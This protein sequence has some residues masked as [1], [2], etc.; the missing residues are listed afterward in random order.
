MKRIICLL[1]LGLLYP[2][3]IEAGVSFDLGGEI[4]SRLNFAL[5]ESGEIWSRTTFRLKLDSQFSSKIKGYVNLKMY[6][7]EDFNF[8]WKMS[9]TYVDY[10]SGKFD[11]RT[12]IQVISWGSAY[13]INP[14]NN[15]NPYDL[16]EEAAF[17]PE[18]RLGVMAIRA[19]YYP[20]NN[21]TITGVIIPYFVP[22]FK[23]SAV[24]LPE[25][26]LKNSEYAFKVTAQSIIGCDISA[27]CFIGKEDYPWTNGEYRDVEIFGGDIIGTIGEVALWAEGA[28]TRPDVGDS[29]F[30][31]AAGGEYTFGNDLYF[32]GQFYHRN[33][34]DTKENY[35][36]AVLRFPFMDIHTLQLGAAYETENSILII[37]PE[38]KISLS[39]AAS[40]ILSGIYVNGDVAETFMSQLKNRIFIKLEYTF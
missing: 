2:G 36:M 8:D 31:I 7:D 25:K 21:F 5:D 24:E 12:G 17:I 19:K 1:I 28:Y 9:E 15:I 26:K 38:I 27:S 16:S 14:T 10:Y 18:E 35:F 4:Y 22:A 3:I 39:D 40:L 23:M 33:Y 29:Y 37:Y 34:T 13:Q 20:I 32:M 6:N 11:I 30:Q